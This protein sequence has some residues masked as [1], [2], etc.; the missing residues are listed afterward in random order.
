MSYPDENEL[1][2]MVKR[3]ADRDEWLGFV[4]MKDGGAWII[5]G[6][7]GSHRTGHGESWEKKYNTLLAEGYLVGG[8][9]RCLPSMDWNDV[10]FLRMNGI[11]I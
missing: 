5:S 9:P 1:V 8:K 10:E 7:T 4:R 6:P 11:E 2:W 3:V